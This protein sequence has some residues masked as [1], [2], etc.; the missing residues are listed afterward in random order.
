VSSSREINSKGADVTSVDTNEVMPLE[1][2][3]LNKSLDSRTML[4]DRILPWPGSNFC[5]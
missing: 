5:L 2:E 4:V 1:V 3:L